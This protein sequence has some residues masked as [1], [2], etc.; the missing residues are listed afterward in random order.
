MIKPELLA[1]GG[2]LEKLKIAILYGADAVYVGG[3]AYS[4]RTAAENF[5]TE[6]MKKGIE[7]AHERGKKVYLTAN[8]LP[9]NE[10]VAEFE[11]F[12]KEIVPLGFDAIIVADLGLFFMVRDFVPELDIHIST[13]ANN[14][15]YMSARKWH[16]LGAKRVVLGRELSLDEIREIR[17]K[18]QP[19]LELEAFV[20][21]AMCISYSGRCLLSNYLANRDANKGNCAHPCRW[22]YSLAEQT[23]AGEYMDVFENERGSF[24]FN[25]KDLC[26]IRYIPELV[27][28]GIT[29]FKIEG[30]VKSEYYVATVVKAY[31]EEIDKFFADPENYV[32]DEA[33]YEELC[34]VS[35]RPYGTGFYFGKPTEDGQVYATSS[36]IRDYDIVGIVK[37]Y[38]EKTM[39]ATISQ[40]NKF[41]VGEQIEI[42]QPGK[43]FFSQTVTCM[44]N[45][46]GEP[47]ESAPHAAMILKM[48][49]KFPVVE[50]AMIRKISKR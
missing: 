17:E 29:S 22:N 1:P 34:K 19:Q 12:L 48:P 20:H 8:V 5:S 11:K 2:S 40:R 39:V 36:Y 28:S 38:D 24:I 10:D 31:R 30:R 9:H 33:Q 13:Q 35:H 44:E 23:R 26:M 47:I 6:D 43:P 3:E 7:F 15:N 50:N 32:F 46:S 21:G 42:I 14:I 27:Q 41:S 16:E 37:N 4:L 49:M 45:E 25:S 18:T